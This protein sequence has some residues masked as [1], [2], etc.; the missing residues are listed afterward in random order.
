MHPYFIIKRKQYSAFSI[1]EVLN[2]E[3]SR[4]HVSIESYGRTEVNSLRKWAVA[5]VKGISA[6]SRKCSAQD[7]RSCLQEIYRRFGDCW[8]TLILKNIRDSVAFSIPMP[9]S[10]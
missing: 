5:I 3:I 4:D 8:L 6:D 2:A 9:M 1:Q 7:E 10:G